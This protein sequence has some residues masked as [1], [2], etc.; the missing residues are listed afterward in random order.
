MTGPA[1]P[2]V[3][4]KALEKWTAQVE[5]SVL[6]ECAQNAS[7]IRVGRHIRNDAGGLLRFGQGQ[8]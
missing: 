7:G 2:A 1:T 8:R 4:A 3:G 6:I 5:T